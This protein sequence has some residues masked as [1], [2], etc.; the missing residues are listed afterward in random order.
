MMVAPDVKVSMKLLYTLLEVAANKCSVDPKHR[1]DVDAQGS[2]I[3][4]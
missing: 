3:E 4:A 2:A 1:K